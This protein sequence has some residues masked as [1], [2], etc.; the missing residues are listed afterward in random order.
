MNPALLENNLE[1]YA[2]MRRV[3]FNRRASGIAANMKDLRL[4]IDWIKDSKITHVRTQHLLDFMGYLRLQRKNKPGTVNRK[5][6]SIK[7]YLRY[8]SF[9]NTEGAAELK[10]DLWKRANTGY[11]GP[12]NVLS[13]EEV[14]QL[15]E[16]NDRQSLL[17][18][19][20]FTLFTLKYRLGLRI[21]EVRTIKIQD[22]NLCNESI[23]IHGKGGKTRVLPLIEDL[24]QM[25]QRWLKARLRM[26]NAA[27]QD[28]LFLSK[29]GQPISERVIQE[30]FKK[31]VE[32]AG[33]LSL[34]KVT[35]HSLRHAFAS[36]A[37]DSE[38]NIITL[39]YFLGHAR[40][41]STEV[42]LHPS[43]KTM[44]K[45]VND[46]A[47]HDILKELMQQEPEIFRVHQH[48][49]HCETG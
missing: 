37:M 1:K 2:E 15:L 27:E 12:V 16:L 13:L 32:Q 44:R 23:T 29:K 34:E 18:L 20:D 7:E 48:R 10:P 33:T 49:P 30:N 26:K 31:L 11:R 24:T 43:M 5:V 45:C 4:F 36:H 21:G 8:L 6:S 9:L 19:R 17:G 39:K 22:I 42:Y 25:L 38:C 47:A 14:Q 46:H 3:C 28:A 40:L 41:S 35:P